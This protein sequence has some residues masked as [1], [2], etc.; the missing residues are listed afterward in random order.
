MS[1]V[2]LQDCKHLYNFLRKHS[3][4]FAVMCGSYLK[5][6]CILM[7]YLTQAQH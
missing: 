6:D 4:K 3:C 2:L 5:V 1:D 7:V